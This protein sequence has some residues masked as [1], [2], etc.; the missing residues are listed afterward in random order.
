MKATIKIG[1]G[2]AEQDF[3]AILPKDLGNNK[4]K[5]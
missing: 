1:V 3:Q 2:T 4:I 5:L